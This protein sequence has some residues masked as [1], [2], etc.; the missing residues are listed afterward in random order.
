MLYVPRYAIW[1]EAYQK[2]LEAQSLTKGVLKERQLPFV[3]LALPIRISDGFANNTSHNHEDAVIQ[4]L[5]RCSIND[6]KALIS[7]M[8]ISTSLAV[9]TSTL[10]K[11]HCSYRMPGRGGMR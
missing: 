6:V 8:S 7:V 10:K 9:S 11:P 3:L 5:L 4:L 2:M 1:I